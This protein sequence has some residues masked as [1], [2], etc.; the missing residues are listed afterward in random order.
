MACKGEGEGTDLAQV[1]LEVVAMLAA[2]HLAKKSLA[3]WTISF[4][5]R[6]QQF[7]VDVC[8]ECRRRRPRAHCVHG[9]HAIA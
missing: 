2:E 6:G 7:S 4:D 3:F 1:E 8:Q 9:G 5:M